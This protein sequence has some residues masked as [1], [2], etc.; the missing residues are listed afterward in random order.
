[1]LDDEQHARQIIKLMK[2][3]NTGAGEIVMTGAVMARF[4]TPISATREQFVQGIDYAKSVGWIEISATTLK[5]TA[6]GAKI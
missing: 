2:E 4:M 6:A 5:L 1:M 3:A